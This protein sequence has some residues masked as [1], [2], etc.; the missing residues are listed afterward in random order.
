MPR[1][2]VTRL[3]YTDTPQKLRV[4]VRLHGVSCGLEV[5]EC[6]LAL[7]RPGPGARVTEDSSHLCPTET[8]ELIRQAIKVC[9]RHTHRRAASNMARIPARSGALTRM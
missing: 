7:R 4:R 6:Q 3:V 8:Q 1:N 2:Y 9:I 5:L